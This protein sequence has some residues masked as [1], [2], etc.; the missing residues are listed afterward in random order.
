MLEAATEVHISLQAARE[1]PHVM[2]D[3]TIYRVYEVHGGHTYS[4]P[5][6]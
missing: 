4:L 2:D 3:F 1:K 5:A 6:I